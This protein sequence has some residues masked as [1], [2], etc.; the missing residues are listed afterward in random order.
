MLASSLVNFLAHDKISTELLIEF[1]HYAEGIRYKYLKL[2]VAM[3]WHMVHKKGAQ[4]HSVLWSEQLDKCAVWNRWKK[5]FT[6][7][8]ER[9]QKELQK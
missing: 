6:F 5:N 1:F 7:S 9:Q 8:T 3:E 4:Q 2:Y